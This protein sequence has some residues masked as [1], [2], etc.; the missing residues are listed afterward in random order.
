MCLSI[1]LT[2]KEKDK[3][4]KNISRKGL[5]VYKVVEVCNSEYYPIYRELDI[6]KSHFSEGKNVDI[7]RVKKIRTEDK[8]PTYY[9]AGF[10]FF[11]K[12]KDALKSLKY[13]TN[14]H[15]NKKFKFIECK[16]HKSWIIAMG[17]NFIEITG[18]GEESFGVSIVAN[19]AIFPDKN[20]ENEKDQKCA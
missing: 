1:L 2:K 6:E 15:K 13:L 18:G 4:L 11:K 3:I 5:T 9:K 20:V 7:P 16:I 14:I 8:I 12:Y 10:H 19:K 17:M